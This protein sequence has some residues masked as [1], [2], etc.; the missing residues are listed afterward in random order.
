MGFILLTNFSDY[1]KLM[2]SVAGGKISVS[3]W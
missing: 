3:V 1:D 2:N